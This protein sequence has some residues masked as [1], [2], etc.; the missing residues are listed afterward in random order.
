[1]NLKVLGS[2]SSGNCYLLEHNNQILIL[3]CGIPIKE[4][5]KGLI[6][7]LSKIAGVIVTHEHLDHSKSLKDFHNM[8]I[9]TLAPNESEKMWVKRNFGD[10]KVQSFDL[11]HNNTKNVGFLI[12]VD[13]QKILYM[14]DLEYCAYSF[15]KMNINHIL[16]ECNYIDE[17]VDKDI[18]NYEHKIKG[19]CSLKTCKNFIKENNSNALRSVI[20]VHL[21][22]G[23]E[24]SGQIVEE[25]KKI[26]NF[27]VF[28]DYA[29]AGKEFELRET[30]NLF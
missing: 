16:I 1:M 22:S 29:K 26:V 21:G 3:D 9:P 23:I 30:E 7:D 24:D 13:N 20:L 15:A 17:Q 8:G 19:H 10:F 18:P 27:D 28:V 4:I 11:P 12:E 5:K 2:G 14:T 6:F 25:V